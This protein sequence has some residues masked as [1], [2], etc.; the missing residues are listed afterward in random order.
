MLGQIAA[1]SRR[2]GDAGRGF[3]EQLWGEVS[4]GHGVPG[5]SRR[6]VMWTRVAGGTPVNPRDPGSRAGAVSIGLSNREYYETRTR[7]DAV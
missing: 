6:P 2:E 3:S 4:G 7:R 1:Q 5:V